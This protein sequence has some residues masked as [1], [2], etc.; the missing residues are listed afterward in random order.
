MTAF[1]ETT[2][3]EHRKGLRSVAWRPCGQLGACGRALCC[4]RSSWQ[5]VSHG[6]LRFLF[7]SLMA[8]AGLEHLGRIGQKGG[9]WTPCP[10]M[11]LFIVLPEYIF[12]PLS[13][14]SADRCWGR[15]PSQRK[16]HSSCSQAFIIT[17]RQILSV[18][19]F[20]LHSKNVCRFYRSSWGNRGAE[21][22]VLFDLDLEQSPRLT[23][24]GHAGHAGRGKTG[25]TAACSRSVRP[26]PGDAVWCGVTVVRVFSTKDH[27]YYLVPR[28]SFFGG[29]GW[30]GEG[31][32]CTY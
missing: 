22:G 8:A 30:G 18:W 4:W 31:M 11:S 10:F 21:K 2:R 7:T 28:D 29:G 3:E 16:G 26:A 15:R 25:S 6:A 19:V 17:S 24:K 20:K 5:R 1:C 14:T 9:F 27:F 13:V 23:T 32:N 12:L